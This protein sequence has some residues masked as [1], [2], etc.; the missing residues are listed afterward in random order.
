[1]DRPSL[2]Q[3]PNLEVFSKEK[4]GLR[5]KKSKIFRKIQAIS[6]K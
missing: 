6:K 2:G 4:K 5:L 3:E 1:M